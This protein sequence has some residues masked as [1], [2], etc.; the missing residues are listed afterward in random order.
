MKTKSHSIGKVLIIIKL[1]TPRPNFTIT[2]ILISKI[3]RKL[4][5]VNFSKVKRNSQ[6]LPDS[7]LKLHRRARVINLA[8]KIKLMTI[9]LISF[10]KDVGE[11]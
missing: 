10:T 8:G 6:L 9:K 5:D 3:I 2:F 7:P 1:H 11:K 4:G